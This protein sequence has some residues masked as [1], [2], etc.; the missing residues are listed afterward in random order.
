MYMIKFIFLET[1]TGEYQDIDLNQ[2]VAKVDQT[3]RA[4]KNQPKNINGPVI[5]DYEDVTNKGL[6]S[7]M[8][9]SQIKLLISELCPIPL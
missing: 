3:G 1:V 4:K 7:Y 5:T 6:I 9:I 2:I 8:Y